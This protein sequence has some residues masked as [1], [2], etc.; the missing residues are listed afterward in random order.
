[1]YARQ[2]A[3]ENLDLALNSVDGLTEEMA[4]K[5]EDVKGMTIAA[6]KLILKKID[7]L[8]ARLAKSNTE[9]ARIVE[10]RAAMHFA[11][12]KMYRRSRDPRFRDLPQATAEITQ[13]LELRQ[14]LYDAAP[15]DP[16]RASRYADTLELWGDQLRDLDVPEKGKKRTDEAIDQYRAA[17]TLREH[18][19]QKYPD[20]AQARSW[21]IGRAQLNARMGDAYRELGQPQQAEG[22]Y[23]R[24]LAISVP[25]YLTQESDD[26]M[27]EVGWNLRKLGEIL[28]DS[29]SRTSQSAMATEAITALEGALCVRRRRYERNPDEI[30][31]ER[32]VS[33]ALVSL[34]RALE[35]QGRYTDAEAHYYETLELRRNFFHSDLSNN[36]YS[37]DLFFSYASLAAFEAK[38]NNVDRAYVH[39]MRALDH[40]KRHEKI[41]EEPNVAKTAERLEKRVQDTRTQFGSP[42]LHDFKDMTLSMDDLYQQLFPKVEEQ[43]AISRRKGHT[44][45]WAALNSNSEVKENPQDC[46]TRIRA[47]FGSPGAP[48]TGR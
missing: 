30:E 41:M 8:V 7:T 15:D 46:A 45:P 47:A 40:L 26:W 2:Q 35:S 22:F 38:R 36:E 1:L 32:D 33:F 12:G 37:R 44:A 19:T 48:G 11:T 29:A 3:E 14:R 25:G 4:V 16:I 28:T 43:I 27:D 17:L 5:L 18:L 21:A 39:A 34:G 24:A 20:H 23:R 13:S 10:M 31:R 9:E 42:Q 6:K